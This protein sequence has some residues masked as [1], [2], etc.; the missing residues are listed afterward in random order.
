MGVKNASN[1]DVI[2]GCSFWIEQYFIV[3]GKQHKALCEVGEIEKGVHKIEYANHVG[4]GCIAV[5][6]F[7]DFCLYEAFREVPQI[8]QWRREMLSDEYCFS[9]PASNTTKGSRNITS[10]PA[11]WSID[12]NGHCEHLTTEDEKEVRIFN[13]SL[14]CK[15]IEKFDDV[16]VIG[17]SH[18]RFFADYLMHYCHKYDFQKVGKGHNSLH[19]GNVHYLDYREFVP[20][21]KEMRKNLKTWLKNKK[22]VAI[23]IQTGGHDFVFWGYQ[24]AMELG[25]ETFKTTLKYMKEIIAESSTKV[26]LRVVATAPMPSYWYWNNHA[27]GAFNAKMQLITEN[28]G[29]FYS[30]AFS[31]ELPCAE[32]IPNMTQNRNHYFTRY[33]NE[34]AGQVGGSYYF[35]L[36]LPQVCPKL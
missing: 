1:G 34:F 29:V 22:E 5:K 2:P 11:T 3:G 35:G 32:D 36:F 26:D 31:V 10:S 7:I 13:A 20:L 21:D 16:Y 27:V 24:H 18:I 28:A 33:R 17:T 9:G 12:Q 30:D 14:T 23:W 25:L 15:C 19:A 4:S 6:V 8:Q